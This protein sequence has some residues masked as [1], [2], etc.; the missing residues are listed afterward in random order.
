M[1]RRWLAATLRRP[2]DVEAEMR[3]E[4]REHITLSTEELVRRGVPAEEAERHA[5]ARFGDLEAE[6]PRLIQ[7]ARYRSRVQQ[8]REWL[9]CAW[10]DV[11]FAARQFRRSPLFVAGVV[12]SLGFGIGVSSTVYSWTRGMLLRP[13]PAVRDVEQLVTVRPDVQSGFG[14]SVDEYREWRDQA[15][16]LSSL[17]ALSMSLF[18]VEPTP[19]PAH[20]SVPLYGMFVSGNYFDVLGVATAQ[21]RALRPEDDV[22]EMPLVAVIGDFAWRR[23]FDSAPDVV[24]RMM[25]INGQLVRIVGI[26]PPDFIGNF[27]MARFDLW[28]PLTARPSLI[29][30]ERDTWKQRDS[31]WL[32]A[33]GRLAPGAS[34]AQADREVRAIATRQAEMFTENRGRGAR[35]I[36]LDTGSV[37]YVA[38]LLAGLISLTLLL[39][40]LVCSN[41]S[42]LFLT[43]GAARARELALR[44]SL[45]AARRRIVGQ[46]L[47]ESGVLAIVG[48]AVGLGIASFGHRFLDSL[49]PTTA[50][51]LVVRS[52]LDLPFF[53]FVVGVTSVCLLASAL[54]P[55][56]VSSRVAV[57]DSLRNGGGGT[58]RGGP[59]RSA[60]VVAQFAFAVAILAC[61]ALFLRRNQDVHDLDLGYRNEDNILLVQAEMSLA[62][63]ADRERWRRAMELA[64]EG[65]GEL[66]D[67]QS[68]ALGSF[69]P[70]GMMG[71]VRLAIGIHGRPEPND[72]AERVLTNGVSP[73]Y[74][75]LMAI[76]VVAGRGFTV[77]DR[78]GQPAVVVVNEAFAD[79]FFHDVAPLGRTFTLGDRAVT[80][81][82]VVRNG[83][84]DYREVDNAKLPLVYY[85]WSQMPS[86]FV[87]IHVRTA[88]NPLAHLADV[89]DALRSVDPA[90]P[91]LTPMTLREYTRVAFAVANS[92][93]RVLIVLG[94]S[95][96]LL[97][98]LGLFSVVSY[99]TSQRT[100]ELGIRM[101]LGATRSSIG[102]L[103]LR[104][105]FQPVAIGAAIGLVAALLLITLMQSRIDQ[106]PAPRL[107]ELA[108][109]TFVLTLSAIAA[110]L[111]PARRAASL[112]PARILRA[113]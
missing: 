90:L 93:L 89:R 91:V 18:A 112:D 36:P 107:F 41:V 98:S 54:V 19:S 20:N 7:S 24:G 100:R 53:T 4:I 68:A 14:I 67:V 72:T 108:G 84:Y 103:V 69:V 15:R 86:P 46:L 76:P 3:E 106:L 110:V 57:M 43:R 105:A 102:A 13:L 81:V 17:A 5:R 79:R 45:G 29:P 33:L 6:L 95:A 47:I 73:N 80:V 71:Y 85:A 65:I 27:A 42:N 99:G 82:G 59:L 63:Y 31:R 16:S 60:F 78:P 56:L 111:I 62:G 70:L 21:G 55:A 10:R 34:L 94:L 32:D 74:F 92:G 40:L 2:G 26:A 52:S 8:R 49:M 61:A 39:V 97:A 77:H 58:S 28:V 11:V 44:V 30:F 1:L 12:L 66:P 83:R 104:G 38:P 64:T 75:D 109:P 48:A 88:G 35:A 50:I 22:E 25:R 23:H 9:R 101:A 51:P 37:R 87:T 96:V 113:D